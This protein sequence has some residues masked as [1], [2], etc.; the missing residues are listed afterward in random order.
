[1]ERKEQ[2]YS[3]SARARRFGSPLLLNPEQR[4]KIGWR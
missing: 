3:T 2:G 4:N 1:M